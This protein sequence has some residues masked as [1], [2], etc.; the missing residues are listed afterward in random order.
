MTSP[1][2]DDQP[3]A[4][5]D[6]RESLALLEAERS[7]TARALEPD[8]RLVY[9]VWGVAWLV[10]FLALWSSAT[11]TGP[12][13]LPGPVAG[14]VFGG[15]LLLA[16]VVTGVHISR[17]VSGVVG[18]T[19]T[20]GAMYGWAWLLGFGG[21]GALTA[22]VAMAGASPEVL[23]VLSPALSGL[24]VGL[25]Y[26]AGGTL[27]QDRAQYSLGVWIL[28]TSAAGALAGYPTNYL[29]MGLLGGGGFL[30]AALVVALHHRTPR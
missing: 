26:L 22:S 1:A 25:L 16:V 17:R 28:G 29:V 14:G 12:L 9:G 13:V 30:V 23:G 21:V 5:P 27:W 8:V 2:H 4:Q 10:G 11:G 20:Q 18:T 6:P 15:L 3:T 19:S 24:V 7:R